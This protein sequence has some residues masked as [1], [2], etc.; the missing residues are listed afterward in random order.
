MV[1]AATT[2]MTMPFR[3]KWRDYRGSQLVLEATRSSKSWLFTGTRC[4]QLMSLGLA[5]EIRV[6]AI[7][8]AR[9]KSYTFISL[10][11]DAGGYR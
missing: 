9:E 10:A 6:N 8:R 5:S 3:P 2:D 11:E 4:L 7:G 1:P